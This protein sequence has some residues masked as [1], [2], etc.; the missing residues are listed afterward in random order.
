MSRPWIRVLLV[1]TTA[2]I[3]GAALST[4]YLLRARSLG[5]RASLYRAIGDDSEGWIA[6]HVESPLCGQK[7]VMLEEF[8][9]DWAACP[10]YGCMKSGSWIP[11]RAY[12]ESLRHATG[13][14]LGPDPAAWASW[15]EAH[16]EVWQGKLRKRVELW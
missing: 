10:W 6:I 14:D 11:R 5:N 13:E 15:F 9:S 16:P 4:A 7:Q 12:Y 8:V 1:L 2:L 3:L